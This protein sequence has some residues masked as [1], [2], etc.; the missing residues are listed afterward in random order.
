MTPTGPAAR[1]Y[2]VA[3][4]P[5]AQ[6]QLFRV[7]QKIVTAVLQ[8]LH[9]SIARDPWRV[10]RPLHDELVG[11]WVA[12]R[13]EYRVVFRIDESKHL[14]VVRRIDHRRDVYRRR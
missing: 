4:T 13:S 3:L 11:L 1:P 6:H 9:G 14:I 10:S 7:P 12:R 2:D 8:G 5:E